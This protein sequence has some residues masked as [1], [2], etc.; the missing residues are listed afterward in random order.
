[1][2]TVPNS[3][4]P[5]IVGATNR[6]DTFLTSAAAAALGGNRELGGE[7]GTADGPN[8]LDAFSEVFDA[9]DYLANN[10]YAKG[11][12]EEFTASARNGLVSNQQLRVVNQFTNQQQNQ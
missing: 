4:S 5:L 2:A 9:S 11:E 10:E 6:A 12:E 3:A 7:S 1:M 8:D